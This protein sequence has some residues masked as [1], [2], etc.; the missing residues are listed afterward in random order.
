MRAALTG[1]LPAG[2]TAARLVVTGWVQGVGFRPWVAAQAKRLGLGGW[3]Q[4]TGDGVAIEVHG[5][6]AALAR[7]IALLTSGDAPGLV[8]RAALGP[9]TATATPGFSIRASEVDA[10]RA[11]VGADTAVCARCLDELFDPTNRRHRHPFIHCPRCGPRFTLQRGVPFDRTRTS[12][13]PFPECADCVA[14]GLDPDDRR[15]HDQTNACRR[16]GPRLWWQAADGA[17]VDDDD[18]GAAIAAAA[19]VLAGGG[20]VALKGVGG[21]H[22]MCRADDDDAVARVRAFKDRPTRPLAV[23]APNVASLAPW[24]EV[25]D[26]ER[27]WL[28][29]PFAPIVLMRRRRASRPQLPGVA[30]GQPWL[31]VM[32]PYAPVHHLLFHEAAGRPADGGWRGRAW[33]LLWVVTSANRRGAPLII[34][35]DE[36]VE[37]LAAIADGWLCH[38]RAIVARADDSV[39][40]V[41]DDGSPC[42]LRRARGFA[43]LPWSTSMST[44]TSTLGEVAVLALGTD[45][46]ATVCAAR[47]TDAV[48]VDDAPP[49]ID[50]RVSPHLGGLRSPAARAAWSAMVETW[51]QT[52]GPALAAV[53]CDRHPDLH[54]ARVAAAIAADVGAPLVEVGHHHAHVAAVLAEH[55]DAERW[56][57]PVIGLA[58]DGFG[59][60]DDGHAWGGEVLHVDGDRCARLAHVWPLPLPGGDRAAR[61]PWR[62]ATAALVV[63]GRPDLARARFP[64]EVHVDA[65]T[66]LAAAAPVTS[67]LGRLFDATAA[68]LGGPRRTTFEG[69]AALWLEGLA[70]DVGDD[71][72]GEVEDL[73]PSIDGD[74][75]VARLDWRPLLQR[76]V[77]DPAAPA[78]TLAQLFHDVLARALADAATTAARQ[79]GCTT[80]VLSGGC[81]A[82]RR[83]DETLTRLLR[84]AG[85]RVWRPA[86]LPVGDGAI[87]AGQAFVAMCQLA[88]RRRSST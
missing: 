44:S 49:A 9:A 51:R 81:L 12:L 87:S 45:L 75:G 2:A 80:V 85:L 21:F 26:A 34:D 70:A 1:Q 13:A 11:W 67:S 17:I 58:L 61:E 22:L 41:R 64:D 53:A 46:K 7:F 20:V 27:D 43:P 77:D 31:G 30:P 62:L 33:P 38:D 55:V 82:N 10:G 3:V 6:E 73:C 18:G 25:T 39:L 47:R 60:G 83:L 14:E 48:D 74:D 32:L 88:R 15:C 52:C 57:E 56:D 28:E 68:L 69:E 19:A 72:I 71:G 79:R 37:A 54:S 66:R 35:N 50:W 84:A 78:P 65:V 86:R 4:N 29:G 24:V 16:C 59:F 23:M 5:A 42:V 76:L 40:R 36:A 8:A 63:V